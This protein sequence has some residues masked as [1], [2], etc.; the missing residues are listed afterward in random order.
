M[1]G[2]KQALLVAPERQLDE[3][4]KALI[5]NWSDT[6]KAI[7]ILEVLDLVIH[8]SLGSRVVRAALEVVYD[9]ACKKEGTTSAEV[10]KLATWREKMSN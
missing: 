10:S 3:S 7:E 6:P 5:R 9:D 8:G 2:I 1:I 4:M